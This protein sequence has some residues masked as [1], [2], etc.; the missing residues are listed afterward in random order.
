MI[1]LMNQTLNHTLDFTI[2]VLN[3]LFL[4]GVLTFLYVKVPSNLEAETADSN[5]D[6][7]NQRLRE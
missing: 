4:V 6:S 3:F 1:F 2:S 7:V 5:E